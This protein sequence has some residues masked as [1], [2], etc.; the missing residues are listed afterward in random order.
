MK[1]G[2]LIVSED[3]SQIGIILEGARD[4]FRRKGEKLFNENPNLFY[5][6]W[7]NLDNGERFKTWHKESE[8][9]VA[10]ATVYEGH[11]TIP[12]KKN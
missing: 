1:I 8:S 3:E 5:I 11:H 6:Y 10:N 9:I 12:P 4:W 2:D 7:V